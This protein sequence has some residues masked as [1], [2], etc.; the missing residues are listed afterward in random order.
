MKKTSLLIPGS[1]YYLQNCAS[2]QY[3]TSTSSHNISMEGLHSANL[4]SQQW[5]L[6]VVDKG[7][8]TYSFIQKKTGE[9]L[10]INNDIKNIV[11]EPFSS[12]GNKIGWHI[13]NH[14]GSSIDITSAA[15]P[16][17]TIKQNTKTNK[18]EV[19]NNNNLQINAKWYLH[20][21][22]LEITSQI[23]N[24]EYENVEIPTQTQKTLIDSG[25]IRNNSE[26]ATINAGVSISKN[27]SS[28][29]SWS[30][31]ESFSAGISLATQAGGKIGLP[32]V[33]D[34]SVST[35]LTLSASLTISSNQ[36]FSSSEAINFS[37]EMSVSVPPNSVATYH[38]Y[39]NM[40]QNIQSNFKMYIEFSA[41]L[42]NSNLQFTSEELLSILSDNGYTLT[43]AKVT[44]HSVIIPVRGRFN[45]SY[46]INMD[47]ELN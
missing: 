15:S 40:V 4:E 8:R 22:D 44:E 7:L 23:H 35:T 47:V 9:R 41:I 16:T 11:L 25:T 24:I 13:H 38:A 26:K 43:E 6:D 39:V 18:L 31:D 33:A 46:G 5:I 21:V 1:V 45:G 27:I 2:F 20:L 37:A 34:G 14:S 29:F 42:K 30:L 32:L 19:G 28:S 10:S 12:S 17:A 36:T 3:L